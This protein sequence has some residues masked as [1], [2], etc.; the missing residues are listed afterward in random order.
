MVGT[1]LAKNKRDSFRAARSTLRSASLKGVG[2]AK[3]G[4]CIVSILAAVKYT[5]GKETEKERR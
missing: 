1:L 4:P 5:E 3:T 2:I